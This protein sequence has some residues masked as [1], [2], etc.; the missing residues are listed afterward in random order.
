MSETQST[1]EKK[2]PNN[3]GI[4]QLTQFQKERMYLY[5]VL[6]ITVAHMIK[7]AHQ[8]YDRVL[9]NYDLAEI[10]ETRCRHS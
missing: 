10:S 2:K 6:V 5:Y 7:G 3:N 1:F 9:I 8:V 4:I